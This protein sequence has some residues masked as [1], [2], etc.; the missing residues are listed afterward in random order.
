[1]ND[2][3]NPRFELGVLMETAETTVKQLSSKTDIPQSRLLSFL[4]GY[5]ALGINSLYK[6]KKALEQII[7][8]RAQKG[9]LA[10]EPLR[11]EAAQS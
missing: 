4:D 9:L 1:M 5:Q 2:Y 8:E 10:G 6:C 7:V 3:K 11:D